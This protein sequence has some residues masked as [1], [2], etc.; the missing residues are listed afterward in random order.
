MYRHKRSTATVRSVKTASAERSHNHHKSHPATQNFTLPCHHEDAQCFKLYK[1]S[2]DRLVASL[3]SR[4]VPERF[5]FRIL[6]HTPAK[7]TEVLLRP[8][9]QHE[10]TP[11][12]PQWRHD[13]HSIISKQLDERCSGYIPSTAITSKSSD[14]QPIR[15]FSD[16]GT[17]KMTFSFLFFRIL[18]TSVELH[19]KRTSTVGV[20]NLNLRRS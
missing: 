17:N 19:L 4:P 13:V 12:P 3:C 9:G 14:Q 8:S 15:E 2:H 18:M 5:P 16:F 10:R 7:H 11:P 1:H 20:W 6:A